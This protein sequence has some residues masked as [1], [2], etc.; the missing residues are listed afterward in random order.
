MTPSSRGIR[1]EAVS[2][3]VEAVPRLHPTP[4]Y[5]ALEDALRAAGFDPTY[6][7]PVEQRAIGPTPVIVA[8]Y[9]ADRVTGTVLDHLADAAIE[10]ARTTLRGLLRQRGV[11]DAVVIPI[12]GPDGEILREVVVPRDDDASPRASG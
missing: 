7:P 6:R 11:S 1:A 12:W 4:G 3:T 10:W 9:L 2:V 8:F 5:A